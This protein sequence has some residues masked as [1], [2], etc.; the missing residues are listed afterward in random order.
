M[1]T[2]YFSDLFV[3]GVPGSSTASGD[4]PTPAVTE[5]S[6]PSPLSPVKNNNVEKKWI[7]DFC[8]GW[9]CSCYEEVDLPRR[10]LTPGCVIREADQET[11]R[12]LDRMSACPLK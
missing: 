4:A 8:T 9:K 7:F 5:L 1:R 3:P 12:R 2:D 6:P 11:W 10:G